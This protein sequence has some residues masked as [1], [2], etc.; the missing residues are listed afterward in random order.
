MTSKT[1]VSWVLTVVPL[2]I[3]PRAAVFADHEVPDS[4]SLNSVSVEPCGT[5]SLT[6]SGSGTYSEPT[7]HLVVSLDGTELLHSHLEPDTWSVG[8]VTVIPGT[9]TLTATIYDHSTHDDIR[10][11]S[12]TTFTVATCGAT[13]PT[14]PSGAPSSGSSEGTA[15][16]DCCPE[17]E[18]SE[19]PTVKKGKVKAVATKRVAKPLPRSLTPI[20]ALFRK[21]HGR[22]PT[23]QEW[24]YWANRLLGDKPQY[25][26]LY[27]AIQWHKLLGHTTGGPNPILIHPTMKAK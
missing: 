14:E 27:G 10:A 6:F 4:V 7:Q 2:L 25:D 23:F 21:V 1:F 22:T 13:P 20:N 8:P 26:A 5:Q 9:H 15:S 3:V 24:E 19:K 16:G 17:P 18:E 12:T 11:S